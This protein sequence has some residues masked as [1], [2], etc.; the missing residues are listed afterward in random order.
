M[1]SGRT[2]SRIW[3][4]ER[5]GR[6]QDA[7]CNQQVTTMGDWSIVWLRTSESTEHATELSHSRDKKLGSSTPNPFHRP[8]VAPRGISSQ[9]LCL[10]LMLALKESPQ[11]EYHKCS[12]E[13]I[14]SM[15]SR[16]A[17]AEGRERDTHSSAIAKPAACFHCC[18][19]FRV[20]L[21]TTRQSCSGRSQ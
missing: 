3:M 17:S 14:V 12:R 21:A 1:I 6:R 5:R 18:L 10:P 16:V 13:G 7:V 15:A 11:V 2:A 19:P 20:S 4:G 9:H 8:R